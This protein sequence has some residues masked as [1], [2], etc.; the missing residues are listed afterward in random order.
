[1]S[2][3]DICSPG[4]SRR[5]SRQKIRGVD[6]AV[7]EWG[8]PRHRLLFWLHGWGNCGA[9]LP[10]V[11]D[12]F[13]DDWFVNVEGFGRPEAAPAEAPQRDRDWLEGGWTLPAFA[14]WPDHAALAATIEAF[15]ARHL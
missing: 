15:F 7:S 13:A 1:M 8:D 11:V 2:N 12:V 9:A 5:T 14:T 10:F 4:V 6:Y 3:T